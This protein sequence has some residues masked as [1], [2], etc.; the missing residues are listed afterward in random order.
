MVIIS[1]TFNVD[2]VENRGLNRH[3]WDIEVP[4]HIGA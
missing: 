3:N 1:C 2:M 4:D